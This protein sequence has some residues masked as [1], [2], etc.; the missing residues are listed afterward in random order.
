MTSI[1][2]ENLQKTTSHFFQKQQEDIQN[3]IARY[4]KTFFQTRMKE[5]EKKM[6]E[7]ACHGVN[8]VWLGLTNG[9]EKTLCLSN[10]KVAC[11]DVSM[12]LEHPDFIKL[13]NETFPK[14]LKVEVYS[15]ARDVRVEW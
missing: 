3:D 4:G 6:A 7:K 1:N 13:V 9:S 12:I 8:Y 5:I 14:P 11:H 10:K 2:V 15:I